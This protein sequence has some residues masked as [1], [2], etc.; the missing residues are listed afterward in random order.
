MPPTVRLQGVTRTFKKV[1]AIESLDLELH[2]GHIYG[3]LGPNGSGKTTTLR[4]IL[5][6]S[7]PDTGTVEL[8]GGPPDHSRLAR[9]GYVPEQRAL[10]EASRVRDTLVFF[11]RMR[12]LERPA[13][14]DL[15]DDWLTRLELLEKAGERIKTLSNGQ[16]QK[17]QIALA[18]MCRPEVLLL[19]EPLTALDPSHQEL[20]NARLREVVEAGATVLVSTHRLREAETLVDHVI[21][22]DRGHKVVDAPTSEALTAAFDGTWRVRLRGDGSWI[23]GPDVARAEKLGEVWM[24]T[25]GEHATIA[26][27]LARAAAHGDA[28]LGL[29]AALPSLHELYLR[30]V[31][32]PAG[33]P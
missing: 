32:R 19:D 14:R 13:A 9:V 15:A 23:D 24:V 21:L 4:T 6:L 3:L 2:P 12:G 30:K 5:G 33:V 18:M 27:L 29:E 20:V 26:P 8:L 7:Q 25:L 10:P 28:L 1:T 17:V 16:Q 22:L 11:G 31:G